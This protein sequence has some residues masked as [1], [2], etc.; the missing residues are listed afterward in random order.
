MDR[1]R[2]IRS[3]RSYSE[4][5]ELAKSREGKVEN[6]EGDSDP[7]VYRGVGM[8]VSGFSIF[9]AMENNSNDRCSNSVC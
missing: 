3:I 1:W 4:A 9:I 6:S 2:R 5:A 8:Y 7:P